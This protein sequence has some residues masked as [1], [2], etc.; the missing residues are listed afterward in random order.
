MRTLEFSLEPFAEE[1]EFYIVECGEDISRHDSLLVR[2]LC[3]FIG[4][5]TGLDI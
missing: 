3:V 1:R 4:S 2:A 5:V